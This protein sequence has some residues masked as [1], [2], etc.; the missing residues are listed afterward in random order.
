MNRIY[1]WNVR[2]LNWPNKQ[3]DIKIFLHEKKIGI[4]GL[5]ETK[6]KER[7]VDKIASRLFQGWQ[8]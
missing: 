1:S 5:L 2:G 3:E 8:W 6:V 4:I 7:N